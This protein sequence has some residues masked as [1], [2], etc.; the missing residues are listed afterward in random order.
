[1]QILERTVLE[2]K[3]SEFKGVDRLIFV[4]QIA[5]NQR[6][7]KQRASDA[8]FHQNFKNDGNMHQ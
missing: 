7:A 6:T 8:Y 2:K 3:F 1:M 5:Y 4:N